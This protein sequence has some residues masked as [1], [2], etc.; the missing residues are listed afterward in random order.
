MHPVLM[1]TLGGLNKEYFFRQLFFGVLVAMF[2]LMNAP[3]SGLGNWV[4]TIISTLLYPYSRFVYESIINFIV[5]NNVFFGNAVFML[6][7]KF[8]TIV[9]CWVL[10]IFIAPIGLVYLYLRNNKAGS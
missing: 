6:A 9:M 5:G 1:K 10:A 2:V 7:V 8:V 4:F 3:A